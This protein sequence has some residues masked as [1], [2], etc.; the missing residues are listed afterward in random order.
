MRVTIQDR[1][2]CA[3]T[4]ADEGLPHG[5]YQRGSHVGVLRRRRG[6]WREERLA[7]ISIF[8]LSGLFVFISELFACEP[9]RPVAEEPP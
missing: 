1:G 9:A 8:C 5:K 7:S 4:R 6:D 2:L 3:P